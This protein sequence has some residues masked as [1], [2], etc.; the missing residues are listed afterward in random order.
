[1]PLSLPFLVGCPTTRIRREFAPLQGVRMNEG[2]KEA[3]D[4]RALVRA[5]QRGNGQA[6][7]KLM[8]N[9]V[10]AARQSL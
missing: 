3:G 5:A 4:N 9:T 10:K 1:M 2:P 7:R 6:F 8:A